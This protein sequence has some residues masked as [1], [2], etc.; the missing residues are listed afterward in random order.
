MAIE[1]GLGRFGDRRLE[2][3]GPL[4]M[5]PWW[6]GR[7]RASGGWRHAGARDAVHALSA[8]PFCDGRRDGA[9]RAKGTAARVAGRDCGGS[10]HERTG[11]GRPAGAG[12][13]LWAGRQGRRRGRPAAA[14]GSGREIASG[15]LLGL[16]DARVWNRDEGQ[17]RH[18]AARAQRRQI[19]SRS[20]GSMRT[21]RAG[22]VLAAAASITGVSDRESDIYEHFARRPSNVHL[23]VRACQNRKIKT[24]PDRCGRAAVPVHRRPAGSG[25]V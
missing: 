10:G 18:A 6:S 19:R 7:A 2:K 13:R 5:R 14:C 17:G 3:G 20:A 8:Q 22:E 4:C 9:S 11:L 24:A 25:P 15:A 23:I 21:T 12:Q 16:V 1:F